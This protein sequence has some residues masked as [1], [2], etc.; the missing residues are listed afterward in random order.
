MDTETLLTSAE[1]AKLLQVD[2]TSIINWSKKGY[3]KYYRTPGGHRRIKAGDVVD[4]V[5]SRNMPVPHALAALDERRIVLALGDAKGVRAVKKML[6]DKGSHIRATFTPT[7]V[8][9]MVELAAQK[10]HALVL[11]SSLDHAHVADAAL[12]KRQE[13]AGVKLVV[14]DGKL[15]AEQALESVLRKQPA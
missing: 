3:L 12:R 14:L 7:V 6:E 4:F 9:A 13:F 11:D 15:D 10:P 2:A 5:R 1:V 8:E